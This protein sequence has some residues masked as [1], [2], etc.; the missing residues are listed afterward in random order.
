MTP[1]PFRRRIATLLAATVLASGFAAVAESA[2]PAPAAA[3][4]APVESAV[5]G[6]PGAVLVR[7]YR[8]Y[9]DREPDRAGLQYWSDQY[10]MSSLTQV[11]AWMSES[12]EYK[13]RWSGVDDVGYVRGLLYEN[14]LDRTPDQGGLD[15]WV[16]L[17][18]RVGRAQQVIHWV[19]TPEMVQNHPVVDPAVCGAGGITFRDIP[20]GRVADIDYSVVDLETSGARCSTAS[21]NANWLLPDGTPVGLGVIDGRVLPGGVDRDD[22]GI[23]GER[24]RPNGPVAERT[25]SWDG[26]HLTAN[27]ATKGNFVLEL[28]RDWQLAAQP[29]TATGWRWAASGI[30]MMIKGQRTIA[31]ST[32]AAN[33]YTLMTT[34][35]S[36]VAFRA[37][38]TVTFGS[39]T[40]MTAPQLTEWLAAQGY[41]DIVKMDGGGSVEFNQGGQTIVAGTGR[42]IPVWLGV[43]CP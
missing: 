43:G 13:N 4:S 12:Q 16:G 3:A 37:P 30:V 10:R 11:A 2:D 27:L 36:F 33:Q 41:T 9:F 40:S 20:G 18:G 31:P 19:Q 35:H 34:R 29:S 42:P 7:L 38:S 17:L 8:A 5:C 6:E 23:I 28:E 39:T 25:Y 21:I 14:L 24:Y 15:Y 1:R 26:T 32:L 22:R